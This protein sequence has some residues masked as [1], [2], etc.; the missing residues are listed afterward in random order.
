MLQEY[1]EKQISV[2][3]TNILQMTISKDQQ[4]IL[5]QKLF[6]NFELIIN[7]F[8]IWDKKS[9]DQILDNDQML[10]IVSFIVEKCAAYLQVL[11]DNQI[12]I[13]D[14]WLKYYEELTTYEIEIAASTPFQQ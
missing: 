11:E 3:L 1:F 10:W 12:P 8:Q 6:N 9:P 13:A 2:N 5:L 4:M 7:I 14:R